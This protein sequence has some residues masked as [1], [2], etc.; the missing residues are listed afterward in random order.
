MSEVI[1]HSHETRNEVGMEGELHMERLHF[2]GWFL[3]SNVR[4]DCFFDVKGGSRNRLKF[5]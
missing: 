3:C 2:L 1:T 4:F 5:S